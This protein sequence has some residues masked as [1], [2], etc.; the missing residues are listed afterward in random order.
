MW[1]ETVH[2]AVP[3]HTTRATYCKNSET[4]KSATTPQH[5]TNMYRHTHTQKKNTQNAHTH[6]TTEQTNKQRTKERKNHTCIHT[7]TRTNEERHP[8]RHP[9]AHA[10]TQTH[11]HTGSRSPRAQI[12]FSLPHSLSLLSHNSIMIRGVPKCLKA[13]APNRWPWGHV[14]AD[15]GMTDREINSISSHAFA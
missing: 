8:H 7:H 13:P 1:S 14:F 4:Q 15:V 5:H 10:H 9:H 2:Y 3:Q 6:T 11:K 12:P